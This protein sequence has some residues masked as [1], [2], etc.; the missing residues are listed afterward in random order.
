M[1][2]SLITVVTVCYNAAI[3]LEKTILSVIAQTYPNVE[4]I[5]IDGGSTDGTVDIIKKYADKLAYWM[6][7]P[8]KG[9]YDAMNKGIAVASGEW[10]NFINSGDCFYS[11][12]V[13][14]EVFSRNN[15]KGN[16]DV[17]YGDTCY[18]KK[19]GRYEKRP[20][21]LDMMRNNMPFCH[22]SSFTKTA[23]MKKYGFDRK[24]RICADYDFF[25]RLWKSGSIF[26]YI[27]VTISVF[28]ASIESLSE[29]NVM[30]SF[31]ENR[32]VSKD[33]FV[34]LNTLLFA[35]KNWWRKLFYQIMPRS[36]IMNRK[37][38]WIEK[39]TRTKSV[40]WK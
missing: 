6:S 15:L 20:A 38:S 24:Y 39:D 19:W 36:V 33:S 28:D 25:F 18:I 5:I 37:H 9:I 22:Q 34:H 7:E 27:P 14:M 26:T 31:Y 32:L 1:D 10:I 16:A 17:V 21:A 23:L 29:D 8:D 3:T 13:L 35:I 30:Q 12:E 4:Y 11:N 40:G 2:N